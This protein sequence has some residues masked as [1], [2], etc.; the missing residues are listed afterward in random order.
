MHVTSFRLSL[1]HNDVD[2]Y[3]IGNEEP[4]VWHEQILDRSWD[5]LKAA[6]DRREKEIV[7]IQIKNLEMKK[8]CLAALY[9]I[10][11]NGSVN[12]S[13]TRFD[14][15]NANLCGEGIIYLSNLVEASLKLWCFSLRH[16]RIDS[17]ES[18]RCLSRSLRSHTCVNQLDLKHCDLGSTPEILL[19]ILQSDVKHID[20][21]NNNIDS[22]GA[23]KIAEYLEGDPPIHSLD[24]ECNRLNDGDIIHI[25]QALKRNTNLKT[26]K[27]YINNITS[28][29]VKALLTC[30]FDSSSLNAISESNHTLEGMNAFD[31]KNY[32]TPSGML[33][34]CINRLLKL[35]K[36]QKL[37]L[38]MKD[39][40]SLIQYLANVP[41]DLIPEVLAFPL[42][43]YANE[44]QHE[45]L[46]IVCST[47]RWWNMPLIYSYHNCVKSDAKRKRD[48]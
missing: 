39:K 23:A 27:L 32:L 31:Y 18:A 24:L 44:C 17:M 15:D 22:F 29:G 4:I 37:L 8:E 11:L 47:M 7:G 40:D 41:V 19:I 6:N 21:E 33:Q 14:F 42:L 28:I 16:N 3:I 2:E 45:H 12:N 1:E 46:N 43:R 36:T 48:D 34:G 9:A 26:L 38:A 20:L 10:F 5:E 35:D 25:L 13:S 30:V